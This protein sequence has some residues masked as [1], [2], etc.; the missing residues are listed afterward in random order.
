MNESLNYRMF[1]ELLEPIGGGPFEYFVTD[2][3]AGRYVNA[4]D[5]EEAARIYM[6]ELGDPEV[7]EISVYFDDIVVATFD[8]R[9]LIEQE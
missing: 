7:Y 5:P 1:D 3:L 2:D 9:D 4:V 8:G 6:D